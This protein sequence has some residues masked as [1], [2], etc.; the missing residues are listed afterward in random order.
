MKM[1]HCRA[2]GTDAVTLVS[3]VALTA[4]SVSVVFWASYL[5]VAEGVVS[6]RVLCLSRGKV[7]DLL[8][9]F[10][11]TCLVAGFVLGTGAIIAWRKQPSRTRYA[12]AAVIVSAISL[13]LTF[14]LPL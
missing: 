12:V 1:K 10:Q 9:V 7:L 5:L 2:G 3:L 14:L 8:G 11:G 4:S 6:P 13:A